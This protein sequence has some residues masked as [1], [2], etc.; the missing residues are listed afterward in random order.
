MRKIETVQLAGSG[1]WAVMYDG[2]VDTDTAGYASEQGAE[3]RAYRDNGMDA[4]VITS[5]DPRHYSNK[6]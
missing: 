6:E 2:L 5:D 4:D 1:Y 3:A